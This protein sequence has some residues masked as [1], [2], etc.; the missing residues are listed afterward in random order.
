MFAD[1]FKFGFHIGPFDSD[2]DA[3]HV[4]GK[5]EGTIVVNA[6]EVFNTAS[7][8]TNAT[9]Y[10]TLSLVNLG[11][12][13]S[14]TT[15]IATASTSETGGSELAALVPF[16]LTITTANATVT[17]G[18]VLGFVRAESTTDASNLAACEVVVRYTQIT[19]AD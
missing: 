14:G 13:A 15:V 17:D 12:D 16:P 10:I 1:R 3:T 2:G 11:T 18:Q 8:T 19:A 4:V 5:A 7:V 9:D 6:V